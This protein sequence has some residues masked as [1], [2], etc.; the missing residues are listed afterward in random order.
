MVR[1][2]FP[3]HFLLNTHEGSGLDGNLLFILSAVCKA[4]C[5]PSRSVCS[6]ELSPACS[7]IQAHSPHMVFNAAERGAALPRPYLYSYNA[8]TEKD[9]R[10][11]VSGIS[12]SF[13]AATRRQD[14]RSVLLSRI[15][16]VPAKC[17][18]PLRVFCPLCFQTDIKASAP[19]EYGL[20]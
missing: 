1:R 5:R 19:A 12:L 15:W 13:C 18:F 14:Q 10:I 17:A 3:L 16:S 11:S 9:T 4:P 2:G 7:E 20:N 6:W 8:N